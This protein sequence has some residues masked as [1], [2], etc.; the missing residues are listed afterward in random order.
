MR[1]DLEQ[2]VLTLATAPEGLSAPDI[3][4][5]LHLKVSQP[6]LWRV[7][8]RLKTQGLVVTTGRARSTRYH[9]AEQVSASTLRSRKLHRLVAERLIQDPTLR[10]VAEKRLRMLEQVNPHGA[11]Y[12][13]RWQDLLNG[14][15]A[16]LLWK[17]VEPSEQ[18]DTLRSESP[19]TGLISKEERLRLFDKR[20][21]A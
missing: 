19:F 17:L 3:L 6:T 11:T 5:R 13:H 15:L 2:V 12:H 14:S 9:S 1:V 8:K 16:P 10:S 20:I 7:L 21:A 4:R 18:A